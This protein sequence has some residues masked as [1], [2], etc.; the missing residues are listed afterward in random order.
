MWYSDPI[1]FLR[2]VFWFFL[3]LLLSDENFDVGV[4]V[5]FQWH[6]PKLWSAALCIGFKIFIH[7]LT[8]FRSFY[9]RHFWMTESG[10]KTSPSVDWWFRTPVSSMCKY[11]FDV[12]FSGKQWT[13]ILP[14]LVF[15]SST[16]HSNIQKKK[17]STWSDK[18]V[19]LEYS[20]DVP[21]INDA[22][23]RPTRRENPITSTG[24][25]FWSA[26]RNIAMS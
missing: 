24:V 22:Q 25:V 19:W 10:W 13:K 15:Q 3:S 26:E 11:L 17:A 1:V 16:S 21:K 7:S 6:H 4:C 5:S 2:R 18:K 20:Y 8:F 14:N 23:V 9:A 12:T